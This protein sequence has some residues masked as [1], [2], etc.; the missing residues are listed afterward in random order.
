VS[1]ASS[2]SSPGSIVGIDAGRIG[3]RNVQ[4]KTAVAT[5]HRRE[6]KTS[7]PI[8]PTLTFTP[9]ANKF[10]GIAI[11][12]ED[13]EKHIRIFKDDCVTKF[14]DPKVEIQ[15]D[16]NG[17]TEMETTDSDYTFTA[18]NGASQQFKLPLD[19]LHEHLSGTNDGSVTVCIQLE[20]ASTLKNFVFGLDRWA[21]LGFHQR[22]T[23][24]CRCRLRDVRHQRRCLGL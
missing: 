14:S 6:L 11:F 9:N 20:S 21:H 4:L 22:R 13:G 24:R 17:G 3:N 8:P 1:I 16:N 19:D 15:Y 7:A 5:H 10:D 2:P 12:H 23:A 18:N